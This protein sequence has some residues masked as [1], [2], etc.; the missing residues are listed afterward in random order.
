VVSFGHTF[1]GRPDAV[2]RTLSTPILL[3]ATGNEGWDPPKGWVSLVSIGAGAV[4]GGSCG[5]G[6][7]ACFEA[8]DNQ[9]ENLIDASKG[10]QTWVLRSTFDQ[11]DD[12][13]GI[14]LTDALH[15]AAFSQ[16]DGVA[17]T[18]SGAAHPVP[19]QQLPLVF[20]AA[21]CAAE[22]AAP[23]A[24]PSSSFSDIGIGVDRYDAWNRAEPGYL[25]L[26]M[27]TRDGSGPLVVKY[28]A[29]DVG[30][31]ITV[32]VQLC[33]QADGACALFDTAGPLEAFTAAAALPYLG[34]PRD[35][36]IAGQ[37]P[38]P[39]PTGVGPTPAIS[40]SAPT[41]GVAD[42][43]KASIA[44]DSSPWSPQVTIETSGTQVVVPPGV[45]S[46]SACGFLLFA[47]RY[48]AATGLRLVS[49]SAAGFSFT[50]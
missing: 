47:G 31:P 24:T 11:Y 22:V 5:A 3:D 41:H 15:S 9:P 17:S 35:V 39:A 37:P 38:H 12:G 7:A 13:N 43:Y 23:P 46:G 30:M 29:L 36:R 21:G 20:D 45:L 25:K 14:Y 34:L 6:I 27:D 40:W 8:V 2:A 26:G 44:C 4:A 48:D 16:Q 10:D 19:V 33:V 1:P 42:A 28:G 32:H 18:L 49:S 50:P